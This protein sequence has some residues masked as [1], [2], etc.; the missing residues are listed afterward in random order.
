ML[1]NFLLTRIEQ[2]P[3]IIILTSNSQSRIDKAFMRRLDAVL[4]FPLPD[5]AQRRQLWLSHLGGRKPDG[6][7]VT[8]LAQYC[9][10]PGGYIR[11]AV[12]NAAVFEQGSLDKQAILQALAWEYQKLGRQMPPQLNR[13]RRP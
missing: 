1:T 3:G 12:L 13:F 6:D 11:N 7:F 2:H 9:E 8:L 10:L 5:I 4:E